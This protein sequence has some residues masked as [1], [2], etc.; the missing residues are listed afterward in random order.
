MNFPRLNRLPPYVFSIMEQLKMQV[1]AQG[2]DVFDFGI[3]NPDQPTPAHI[4]DA[5]REAVLR[6]ELHRYAPSKGILPLRKSICDWYAKRFNVQLDPEN[7]TIATIG[8][9]EGLAH[10]ALAVLGAGDTVIVPNPCY[11]VHHFGAVIADANV[12]SLP[13]LPGVDF[14]ASLEHALQTMPEKPKMLI[15][16][17]PSNPSALCVDLDFFARIVEIAKRY[18]IWVVQDLAYADIVFDGYRA[19]SI[20]QV[21]G[22]KEV[23]V[24]SYT[25]SKTYNM[26]GWR[27]GFIS[28]N[29]EL[30]YALARIKSYVDYGTFAPA[31]IAAIA[32][33]EGPQDCVTEICHR[34]QER[35]NIMCAGLR[36]MGWH[37]D[38]PK[39]TMFVWAKIPE[40]FR[41][42]K[43]LEF[44]K[45]LLNEAH[46]VVSP[47]IG[48]GEQG[49]EYV[50]IGLVESEVRM[51]QALQNLRKFMQGKLT[52]TE[53]T[54]LE[55]QV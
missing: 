23:A 42:L 48:F 37:V 6:P 45:L 26:A 55:S 11:P 44:A 25:L 32:A 3:G 53:K 38:L 1:A 52:S 2:M 20:L 51:Q 8:S 14:I 36:A 21:P 16:N 7:E 12:H 47:G 27:I 10:L 5:L 18:K 15:L 29:R 46:V 34:Y 19:P 4:V 30:I 13:L 28:G 40:P 17:F 43:S 31:Q 33:L 49:D 9:K 50:R 54:S 35:R 41:H 22:A 24:E 39:A